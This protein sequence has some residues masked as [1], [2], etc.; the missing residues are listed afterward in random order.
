VRQQQSGQSISR[1]VLRHRVAI[2][3]DIIIN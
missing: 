3:S 1:F 2:L